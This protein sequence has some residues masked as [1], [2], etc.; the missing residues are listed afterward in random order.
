MQVK[1]KKRI[2]L[3]RYWTTRYVLT[4]VAGLAFI[5]FIS[6]IWIRY[7]T[8][9]H[10]LNMMEFMA[11]EIA[12]RFSGGDQNFAEGE[13][14]GKLPDRSRLMDLKG[15][16]LIYI[17]DGNGNV[18]ST[19]RPPKS[20]EQEL[21][22]SILKERQTVQELKTA[23]S[24]AIYMVK[25]P[26][27]LDSETV[28]WVVMMETKENLTQ[29]EQEYRQLFLVML[30]LA[31]LGWAAIYFLSKRLAHP[32]KEVAHAARQIQN[33]DYE[34]TLPEQVEEE[35][36]YELIESFREMSKQLQRLEALRTELL[37]GVT[38]ELKTPV[39]SISGLLQALNDKV[40]TGEEAEEFLQ[41]SLKESAKMK[42]MVEDLL[43]FNSFAANAIPVNLD[44]FSLNQLTSD[45]ARE[46]AITHEG[47]DVQIE[48]SLPDQEILVS[49]DSMRLHQVL[50]NLVN[51]AIH[52]IE[53][54]GHIQMTAGLAGG[55]AFIDVQDAG[56]GIPEAEQKLIFER[57]YRGENKK[58]RIGGLGLGLPFS[59]ML[60]QSMGGD[61]ELIESTPAGTVFRMTLPVAA[62][63]D[64]GV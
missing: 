30:A 56:I 17:A 50:T 39:A 43:A 16:P 47:V 34:I 5:A 4:L 58:Y 19:N 15:D 20:A 28:G 21:P 64:E 26:I 32:I 62:D 37:A 36:V 1:T 33:G 2:P 48:T 22:L 57:F 53:A 40:V 41:I 61:L 63:E 59:K 38:H 13:R 25:A 7:T 11:Q 55:Q 49:T 44:V 35:E 51:N 54:P 8:L 12:E 29:V 31:V 24:G 46:W 9:E 3:Q 52:A 10:R 6:A 45:F 27:T 60:A 18:L 14:P 42:K 23:K